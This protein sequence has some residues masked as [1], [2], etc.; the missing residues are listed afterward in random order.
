MARKNRAPRREGADP[1]LVVGLGRFG[2]AVCESLVR[3]GVE[4]I[5]VDT[6]EGRVQKYADELTHTVRA[7]GTDGE[8]MRQ[9]GVQDLTRA[10]VA[11]G[12][13]I[14]SSVLTVITLSEA[15][16]RTIYAK[17][18]TRKHG[19][20]L[21]SI[22]ATHVIYPEFIMGQRVAHMVTGGLSDYLEF[23]DEFAIARCSAPEE[24][25]GRP[26][27]ESAVRTRHT[28][29]VVGV[30]RPGQAFTYAVPET[31]V[32]PGDELVLSGRIHDVERFTALAPRP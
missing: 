8:A 32:H 29:T 17:A 12:S 4:V 27:S 15:G 11:I 13:D 3:Q 1:V 16:V 22:G 10:V 2:S 30:K 6:D 25:W 24:T 18:I 28:I 7:D 19:K 31:V 9:L 5:A 23:E 14:E 26:L 20:I 21:T